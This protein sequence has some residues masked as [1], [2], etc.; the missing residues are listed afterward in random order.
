M[1]TMSNL[2]IHQQCGS[3]VRISLKDLNGPFAATLTEIQHPATAAYPN[4]SVGRCYLADGHPGRC[5]MFV[6]GTGDPYEAHWITWERPVHATHLPTDYDWL[7][8][9]EVCPGESP[10]PMDTAVPG[11][12]TTAAATSS[13]SSSP[14]LGRTLAAPVHV[15]YDMSRRGARVPWR[16]RAP[17]R[18][19]SAL[20]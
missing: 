1:D 19:R 18:L 13:P 17:R 7:V 14:D 10:A 12:P 16:D 8:R 11:T 2:D 6:D 3:L 20:G 15:G 4:V 5:E 9:D